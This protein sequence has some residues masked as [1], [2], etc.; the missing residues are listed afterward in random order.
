MNKN[1][2]DISDSSIQ[3][4]RLGNLLSRI[5]DNTI[6]GRI[7]KMVFETMIDD[8]DS[9]DSIIAKKGLKQVTDSGAIEKLVDEVIANNPDQVQQLKEGKDQVIG[10]LVGQAMKL[11]QGKANPGQVNQLLREKI[12][13]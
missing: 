4:E 12:M 13:P 11:S 8:N 5:L 2:L 3:A 9:V 10:F 1:D 6:S 7:A